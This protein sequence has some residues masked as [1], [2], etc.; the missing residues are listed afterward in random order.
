MT[1]ASTDWNEKRLD[2][3]NSQ[4]F[5]AEMTLKESQL[6]FI[7]VQ[8]LNETASNASF[9]FSDVKIYKA[10]EGQTP[11]TP[12]DP[13]PKPENPPIENGYYL[14]SS[15]NA[16]VV[17][18][19]GK[20]FY[21][22]DGAEG[23]DYAFASAPKIDNG[24]ITFAFSSMTAGASYQLRYQPDFAVGTK[25]NVSFT[26]TVDSACKVLYSNDYKVH[27]F[28]ASGSQTFT[29][30]DEVDAS[31]PFMIQVKECTAPITITVSDITIEEVKEDTEP[32]EPSV[33]NGYFLTSSN[34][35]GVVADP[36]KWFYMC[37][38]ADG[39]DYA[40]A[41]APKIDNGVITFAF[42][43]MTAGASYQLRYQPDFAVDTEYNLSFKVT[44]DGACKV[45]YSNDYKVY[46]FDAAG[47]QIIT[48]T[49]KV[50]ASAPFM[51]QVKE[52]TAPIT[53]SISDISF[54]EVKAEPTPDPEQPKVSY[55]LTSSNKSGVV[56]NPGKWFYFCDD[57]KYEFASTPKYDDGT[58]TFAF[59]SQLEGNNTYQLRYQ[60]NL[61][62]G[63]EYSITFTVTASAAG[64]LGYG[65]DNK[66]V[67]I[68]AAETKTIT[69]TGSVSGSD[70][71]Y[72]QIRA[73][74]RS[75][76][77]TI[78]VSNIVITAN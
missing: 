69:W 7:Q 39:T 11:D 3:T 9:T 55:D 17:A 15:N 56:S 10:V 65:P 70:P 43:S 62:V 28:E 57:G 19:P 48:Y 31:A 52:C 25:Y 16:G 2:G 40:F 23:T 68:A 29:W 46:V 47:S 30:A 72:I 45:L 64:R 66:A 67:D 73:T 59:N 13:D 44:V 51:I 78:T 24:V 41:S 18:D 71:F 61:E 37:D 34:N 8:A 6:I 32:E 33:E 22:C 1:F 27:V 4:T 49:D 5:T 38:G 35:A 75:A 58:I 42:S 50:D 77:I 36:G 21:M 12:V 60:P 76:P 20:W 54:E 26:I 74:D 53:I 14:T 63:T